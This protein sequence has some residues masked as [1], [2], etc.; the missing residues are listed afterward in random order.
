MPGQ[1]RHD[2]NDQGRPATAALDFLYF[3]QIF[4]NLAG[5]HPLFFLLLPFRLLYMQSDSLC[6]E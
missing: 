4:K 5:L 2:E 3:S 6:G 1:A